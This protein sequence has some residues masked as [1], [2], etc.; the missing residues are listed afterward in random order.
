MELVFLV[1]KVTPFRRGS[2]IV[3]AYCPFHMSKIVHLSCC[4]PLLLI[5]SA[6][7]VNVS[8]D[9]ELLDS[10]CLIDSGNPANHCQYSPGV[11]SVRKIQ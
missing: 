6:C 5:L 4:L 8:F 9:G 11:W 2:L 10:L 7:S 1:K 3:T